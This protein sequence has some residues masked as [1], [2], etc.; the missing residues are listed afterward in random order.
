[1]QRLEPLRHVTQQQQDLQHPP[2]ILKGGRRQLGNKV[3]QRA[4]VTAEAKVIR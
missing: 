1:M 3:A 4:T 2:I